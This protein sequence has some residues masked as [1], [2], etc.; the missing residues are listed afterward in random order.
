MHYYQ[1]HTTLLTERCSY[2]IAVSTF[3]CRY[4][5]DVGSSLGEHISQPIVTCIMITVHLFLCGFSACAFSALTLLIG[6]QEEHPAF[7]KLS[8]EVLVWLSVWSEVHPKDPSS[9]ASFKS[10]MVLPFRYQLTLFILE[11]RPL[12]WCSIS[13]SSSHSGD[14]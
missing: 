2:C 1:Y 11:K 4:R 10:K 5:P 3:L 7:K 6:R 12:K 8:D 14:V 9:L 13:S